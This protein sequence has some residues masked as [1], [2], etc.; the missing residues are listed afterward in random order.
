MRELGKPYHFTVT[1]TTRPRRPG[2]RDGVDYI[3]IAVAE[4]RRMIQGGEL[5]EW[6]EVY[7]NLYGVPKAQVLE[8]LGRG[9]DVIMKIDVQGAATVRDLTPEAVFIFLSP[10]NIEELGRRLRTRMTESAGV[11]RTRLKTAERELEEAS[12]FD[13]IVVNHDGRIDKAVEEIEAVVARERVRIPR[14]V[15]SL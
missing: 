5:L 2:E 15:V 12:H 11:L 1:I 6:A 9:R 10:P 7:G 8:A 13:H 4:F 14:R 3:F